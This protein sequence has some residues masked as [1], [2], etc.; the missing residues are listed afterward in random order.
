V[1]G[2]VDISLIVCTRNR[3]GRLRNLLES[4][5]ALEIPAG[6][7][8]EVLII[9][10]G[11]TDDT[12]EI[13]R[14]FAG[15]LPLRLV[16]EP[17]AGLCLARTRGVEEARGRHLCW[18]DDDVLLDPLWLA[19]YAEA[20]ARHPD[21]A[22]F[23]GRILP[24][25]EP[26]AP[27]WFARAMHEW[28]LANLVARRDMGDSETPLELAGGR[29]PWGANYAVRAREQKLHSYNVELGF[30]PRHKRTGEE[31]DL[32]YRIL[33]AGGTGWWVPGARVRH[34]IPAERQTRTYLA[35]YFD[36]AGRTAA[37]LHERFP[38]DNA[39]EAF[40]R[41]LFTRL[42]DPL[43]ELAALAAGSV[44]GAVALVGLSR[45]SLRFLARQAFLRGVAAHRRDGA[46]AGAAPTH[47]F[48]ATG[49]A[50]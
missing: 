19:A 25:L 22:V 35:D 21:A 46:R 24:E 32:A 49:E 34:V 23:G 39:N 29:I 36:R 9:D 15:R 26:P 16:A 41:P 1:A 4:A 30:S 43:L 31:T 48:A 50:A 3:A 42:D 44:A 37:F 11:S 33:K 12:G 45:M 40:G 17:V 5:C 18:V 28:P 38:G 27:A 13:A 14:A 47:S 2:A 10:N 6:L 8:W 20:F 7:V